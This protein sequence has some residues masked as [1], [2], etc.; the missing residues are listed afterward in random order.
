MM[1]VS[2]LRDLGGRD[3][4]GVFIFRSLG[5][6][7]PPIPSV[8]H[9]RSGAPHKPFVAIH[10]IGHFLDISALPGPDASSRDHAALTVWRRAVSN[11]RAYRALVELAKSRNAGI[12]NRATELS[13]PE[14]LWARSYAQFIAE[15][16]TSRTLRRSLVALRQRIPNTL[17]YPR[18]W[19]D[20]DFAVIAA[21]I[22]ELFRGLDGSFD[23]PRPFDGRDCGG[24]AE[25][26]D[27]PRRSRNR[28]RD[29]AR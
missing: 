13:N 4:D 28:C 12:A 9:V 25:V 20:D 11:S 14:E 24:H 5:E 17:Y 6:G 18:H 1:M 2:D 8:I 16:S 19:D 27:Q 26:R 22:D 3:R 21:A 23:R 10:Q 7:M 29:A 15:R